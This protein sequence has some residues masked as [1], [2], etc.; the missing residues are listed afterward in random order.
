MFTKIKECS[1]T[2]NKKLVLFTGGFPYGSGET[3]LETELPYLSEA[4][5]E[6][7]IVA[8]NN[9]NNQKREVPQNCEVRRIDLSY[10]TSMRLKSLKGIFSSVYRE[11]LSVIKSI[12]RRS[13]SKGMIS[14]ALVSLER[15]KLVAKYIQEHFS[16]ELNK[17][18]FYSYWCDDAALG[19]ALAHSQN[20]AVKGVCRIH[21][22]DVYFEE[23]AVNYLP[24][25]HFIGYHLK[26]IYSIS[27]D[28]IEYAVDRWKVNRS[29]F[30]L[31][32]LGID[33]DHGPVQPKV[34]GVFRIVSCS[35]LIR[36]KRVGLI[37]D[38]LQ[39]IT[40]HRIEWTHIGNGPLREDLEE[41]VKMLQE[42]I[43]VNLV[44]RL[45]NKEV[46]ELYE[47]ICPDLF[48]N[49]SSSEG[50]PVSIMEAMSYGIP[51]LATDVGGNGEI[52]NKENGSLISMN[53]DRKLLAREIRSM[54]EQE[55]LTDCAK[56]AHSK[57][58]EQYS[59]SK[60]YQKFSDELRRI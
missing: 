45:P 24:F 49:V 2:L 40:D 41:K 11:E 57:W 54:T 8:S 19:I 29:H 26:K 47:S 22:W 33:N 3:F 17:T 51:V 7:I 38:A 43:T 21:R 5:E 31:S 15:G 60:N 59:G 56:A 20:N 39:E 58:L 12:Y 42:N 46:Y 52:V 36:V 48:I 4:F 50:V 25:R 34:D 14:T 10:S 13:V 30:E 16:K 9:G 18:V 1:F 53:T 27:Q 23:S 44:G 35:N 6:V 55:D 28:G 37:A 32:R